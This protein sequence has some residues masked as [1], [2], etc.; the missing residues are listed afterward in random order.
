VAAAGGGGGALRLDR[1]S[2][3]A[4]ALVALSFARTSRRQSHL[5]CNRRSGSQL[6]AAPSPR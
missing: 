2:F 5:L 6:A 1:G 3:A 4:A